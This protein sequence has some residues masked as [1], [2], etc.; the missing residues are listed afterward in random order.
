VLG[1]ERARSWQHRDSMEKRNMGIPARRN[2]KHYLGMGAA[3]SVLVAGSLLAPSVAQ[4]APSHR[5]GIGSTVGAWKRAY[6]VDRG[7]SGLCVPKNTCFGPALQNGDSGHTYQFTNVAD[8]GGVIDVYQENFRNGTTVRQVERAVDRSLPA[9]V[10][11]LK[12]VVGTAGGS[13]GLINVTSRTLGD[14]L[15]NPKIGDAKGVVGIELQS[16]SAS[17]TSIYNPK[18]VQT[19][20]VAVGPVTALESC[21]LQA[22]RRL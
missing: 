12:L 15:G 18:N 20:F 8:L 1:A 21:E 13:C 6:K 16:L 22:E 7:K 3:L 19:A 4:A 5:P 9:N 2:R 10:A 14:E 17:H 11:R